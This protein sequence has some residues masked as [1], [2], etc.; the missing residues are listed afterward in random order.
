ME[1]YFSILE[2]VGKGAWAVFGDLER[3]AYTIIGA[4]AIFI[5]LW[6]HNRNLVGSM[7]LLGTVL[8]V[9]AAAYALALATSLSVGRLRAGA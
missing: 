1:S 4:A 5:G 9:Y 2:L 8:L 3:A 6:L 7:L